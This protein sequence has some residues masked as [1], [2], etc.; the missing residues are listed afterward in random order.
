M[1]L[2]ETELLFQE[3]FN[4]MYNLK[5][6]ADL[7]LSITRAYIEASVKNK[8]FVGIVVPGK[9]LNTAVTAVF[10]AINVK[11]LKKNYV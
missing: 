4:G 9:L 3:K 1:P 5:N 6:T 8:M 2:E 10:V 11:I 7:V